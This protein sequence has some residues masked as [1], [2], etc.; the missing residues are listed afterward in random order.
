MVI[1][2]CLSIL[3]IAF[4]AYIQF[5]TPVFKDLEVK[6]ISGQLLLIGILFLIA[7]AVSGIGLLKGSNL[8]RR[9]FI[10]L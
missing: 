7:Y 8:F 10:A 6:P 3:F 9:L 5:A 2:S 1:G 4:F